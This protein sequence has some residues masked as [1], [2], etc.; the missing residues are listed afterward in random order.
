MFR[1]FF[2]VSLFITLISSQPKE[3][4]EFKV[5]MIKGFVIDSLTSLPIMD[6]NVD[7]YTG[8]G[9]LKHSTI[10]DEFGYYEKPIV[11]YLWKPK[12]KFYLHNYYK[13]LFRLDPSVLDSNLDMNINAMIV[14]VPEEKRIPDLKKSTITNRAETFFIKGNVF[15][16]LMNEESAERIIIESAEA[17]ETSPGF[18]LMKVN[19]D[20]YD[21]AR[22]YVP[23]EGKYENIS[24]IMKSLL[25]DPIFEKSKNPLYLDE[26]LLE[27]TMVY[28]SIINI[29]TGEPVMGAEIIISE[30]FK[31]RISDE[32]GKYAFYLDDPGR[33]EIIMNPPPRFKRVTFSR[34]ELIIGQG[35][36]GWFKTNFYVRP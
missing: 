3:G 20:H 5:N 23:Q 17:I 11:G 15:Y 1:S 10:T 25:K 21:I 31:R 24:F 14:P 12:V 28:G 4:I 22:C 30:P 26:R 16:H 13:K 36:G 6:V 32:N 7:I 33:Y 35:R 18:V 19:E 9:V 27:P 34:P 29:I 8:N 2:I